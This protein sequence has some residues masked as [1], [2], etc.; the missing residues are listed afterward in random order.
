MTRHDPIASLASLHREFGEHGGVNVSIEPSTTFTVL[1]PATMPAIF[2]GQINHDQGGCYLYG[3][4]FNPTVVSLGKQLAAIEGGEAGYATASGMSAI[5][6]TL[7]QYLDSGDH[8]VASNTL[9]GGTYALLQTFMPKKA[10]VTTSFVDS[11][12]LD[13]VEAAMTPKTKVLYVEAVSNPMLRIADVPRLAE[14]AHKHGAILVVDGTFAPLMI[15]AIPLG[16]DVVVHSITKFINGASDIIAGAIIGPATLQGELM[17]LHCGALMLTGPT[18][19][20]RMAYEISA[21]LPHL[22][23]RM[24]EHARRA[25][26]YAEKMSERNLRVI[27]PGLPEH[28]DHQLLQS[29]MNPGFG[30]GGILCLD[31]GDAERAEAFMAHLQNENHFGLLAVSLGYHDTLMTRPAASTSSEMSLEALTEAGIL[32]GLVR[33]SVG[34]TGTLKERWSQLESALD[35][36]QPP[37]R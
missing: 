2:Q 20:P 32:P 16:A 3:R 33:M 25:Q 30:F 10:N 26:F 8:V 4:H 27:Y 18:M 17:D 14:I 7:L 6:C 12:N 23:L 37:T 19:D 34:Y 31:L 35:A 22:G 29:L 21:R 5:S 13:A 15:T 28:P 11:S 1:D 36:V 24:A 9:Y